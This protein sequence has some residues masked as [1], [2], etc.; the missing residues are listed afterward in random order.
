MIERTTVELAI[1]LAQM[2]TAI[3]MFTRGFVRRERP[4]MSLVAAALVT[5]V[6]FLALSLL[7]GATG[8]AAL[9]SA[10]TP[11]TTALVGAAFWMVVPI[12]GA[13]FVLGVYDVSAWTAVYAA[14]VGY[15][16][17]NLASGA[18]DFIELVLGAGSTE[19]VALPLTV[20]V[21][22]LVATAVYVVVWWL[23]ARPMAEGGLA[24]GGDR[25][26][27][28]ILSAV[29]LVVILFDTA[30]KGLA[31][32]GTSLELVL[33][34]K[35]V[36]G[37]ACALVLAMGNEL[38]VNRHLREDALISQTMLATERHQYELSRENIEAINIKCHDIRHQIRQLRG[39]TADLAALEDIAQQV[40]IYDSLLRTGNDALDVI[41]SEKGLVCEREGIDLRCI[42]DGSSLSFMTPSDIYALFGNALDNAIEASR[43]IESP[44][45]RSIALTVREAA[46]MASIHVENRFVGEVRLGAD[47][48][49]LTSKCDTLNHGFGV[50]SIRLITQRY[51]GT[52][53][54]RAA[55]G[56][57][58]LNVS[59]PL[60]A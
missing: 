24:A 22:V 8:G 21:E 52:M 32:I 41:L 3:W 34:L 43:K 16:L 10:E 51:G 6:V 15:T 53:V 20:L 5:S 25:R 56:V 46:G 7:G 19:A 14:A 36:H 37:G 59:L 60:P 33:V 12:V 47:G 30:N 42:A 44:G 11:L 26:M 49:P 58:H 31:E 4:A 18:A 23:V 38:L 48:L 13:L 35:L 9:S 1:A 50:R 28:A 40:D 2:L 39:R 17:Q 29:F 45:D 27:L 57:F 55:D 54:T